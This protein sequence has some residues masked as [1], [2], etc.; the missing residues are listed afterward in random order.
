MLRGQDLARG[1]ATL[2]HTTEH[3]DDALVISHRVG[4]VLAGGDRARDLDRQGVVHEEERLLRHDSRIALRIR[5]VGIG[6]VE[7]RERVAQAAAV[8]VAIEAAAIAEGLIGDVSRLATDCGI[9]LAG[10]QNHRIADGLE[11]ET[12]KVAAP[13]E[14]VA[15]IDLQGIDQPL[16]RHE[17]IGG[18]I[19]VLTIDVAHHDH[20]VEPLHGP[21]VLHE[22][23]RE[24]VE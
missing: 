12:A 18:R 4:D 22:L 3:G 1:R 14:A 7:L 15:G 2:E 5:L 24:E 17:R 13:E 10:Q 23:G 19:G 6:V 8:D 11:I 20:A 16:L 21:A 9:H